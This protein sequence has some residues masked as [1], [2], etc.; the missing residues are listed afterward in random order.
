[1]SNITGILKE[2][3]T[4]NGVTHKAGTEITVPAQY[5]LQEYFK[6]VRFEEKTKEREVVEK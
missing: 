4:I 5:G 1:M 6:A 3:V 2:D